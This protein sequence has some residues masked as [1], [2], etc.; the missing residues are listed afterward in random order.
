MRLDTARV[1]F[2]PCKS[3][4]MR[5]VAM[6]QLTQEQLEAAIAHGIEASNF[7]AATARRSSIM[8]LLRE[9]DNATNGAICRNIDSLIHN[10]AIIIQELFSQ[11]TPANIKA[12]RTEVNRLINYIRFRDICRP[13]PRIFLS[14]YLKPRAWISTMKVAIASDSPSFSTGYGVD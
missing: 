4:C 13:P 2:I 10:E 7:A 11:P 3:L 12:A 1:I 8:M 14:W 5:I 9:A 6:Q